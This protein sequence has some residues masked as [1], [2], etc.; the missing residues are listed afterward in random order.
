MPFSV[1]KS[2]AGKGQRMDLRTSKQMTD[3]QETLMDG[4]VGNRLCQYAGIRNT[5]P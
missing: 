4:D 3:V 1:I 2:R 5:K